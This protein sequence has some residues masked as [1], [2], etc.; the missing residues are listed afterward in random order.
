MYKV[1]NIEILS[2]FDI[3]YFDREYIK[4]SR[5]VIIKKAII[6]WS[7]FKKWD[8]RYLVE[9][10]G[11][12][13]VKFNST[14]SNLF[15]DPDLFMRS[16]HLG[17]EEA[18][19]SEYLNL[20]FQNNDPTTK[21]KYFFLNGDEACFF[22]GGKRTAKFLPLHSDFIV[23]PFIPPQDLDKV[24]F[25]ISKKYTAS[26]IH[27]DVN[28]CHNFNAQVRGK[29]TVV[30]FPPKEQKKLYMCLMSNDFSY[31][32]FSQVN[33]QKINYA[34]F[35][36]LKG[37]EYIEGNLEAGDALFLPAF[38]I[39]HFDHL[40]P[41]NINVNFWWHPKEFD[42]NSV[43]LSWLLGIAATQM[44]Y[45]N[46]NRSKYNIRKILPFLRELDRIFNSWENGRPAKDNHILCIKDLLKNN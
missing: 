6:N 15:P 31:Y 35:P 29:K 5:P 17:I 4:R 22:E 8:L 37:V 3:E 44:L 46:R 20:L 2:E 42:L 19:F 16:I 24:G 26:S 45:S 18:T 32:N 13:I 39:H 25:W 7:A 34:K 21:N 33:W 10:I 12:E 40:D 28:G 23:P 1:D 9:K 41:I 36:A 27:Y 14:Y 43:S 30:L 11:N 38:W